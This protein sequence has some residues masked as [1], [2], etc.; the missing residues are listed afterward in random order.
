[1]YEIKGK[2]R[3]NF[4]VAMINRFKLSTLSID[5]CKSVLSIEND[6]NQEFLKEWYCFC[7]RILGFF[8]I[9]DSNRCPVRSFVKLVKRLNPKCDRLFKKARL[10]PKDGVYF[11][12]VPLGHNKL[13]SF[14][15]EISKKAGLSIIYTNHS[16]RATTVRVLDAAQI[17]SRHIMTVTGHKSESSLKTY[18]G[19]TDENTK[20]I[21]SE[22]ISERIRGKYE[23]EGKNRNS[24][25]II[26]PNFNLLPLTNSQEDSLMEDLLNN[27]DGVDEL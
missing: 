16:C 14:M 1:M 2:Y 12:N 10:L 5:T 23:N 4:S 6:G 26:S 15:S 13:G 17:P 3:S 25:E 9:S 27:N 22:K 21:M 19:I 24:L 7:W 18:S 20:Q 11:D 8:F